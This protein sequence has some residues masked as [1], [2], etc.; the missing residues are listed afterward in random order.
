MRDV[1]MEPRSTEVRLFCDN[2]DA[3]QASTQSHSHTP[4]TKTSYAKHSSD[5]AN[6]LRYGKQ[7]GA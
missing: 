2:S 4:S 7:Q 6:A 1:L 5:S 3:N